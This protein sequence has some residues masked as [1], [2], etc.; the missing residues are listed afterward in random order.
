MARREGSRREHSSRT[1]NPVQHLEMRILGERDGF[2]SE[3]I[4]LLVREDRI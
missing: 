3:L 4:A 1:L 2:G